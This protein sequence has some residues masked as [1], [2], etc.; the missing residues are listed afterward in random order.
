METKKAAEEVKPTKFAEDVAEQTGLKPAEAGTEQPQAGQPPKAP[1]DD[2][3]KAAQ[4]KALTTQRMRQLEEEIKMIREKR[5]R[6]EEEA[7][8]KVPEKEV[9]PGRKVKQLGEEK[10]KE[11]ELPPPVAQAKRKARRVETRIKGVS[12]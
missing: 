1:T 10:K 8:K 2:V 6:E 12:G 11:E 3:A 9:E 5:E 4:K 7:R